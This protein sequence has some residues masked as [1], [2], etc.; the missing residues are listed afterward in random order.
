MDAAG[1]DVGAAAGESHRATGERDG[2]YETCGLCVLVHDDA[3]S[4]WTSVPWTAGV[5]ALPQR[6]ELSPHW[7]RDGAICEFLVPT[8]TIP[9]QEPTLADCYMIGRG[10]RAEGALTGVYVSTRR[11]QLDTS[12]SSAKTLSP[13]KSWRLLLRQNDPAMRLIL[14]LI[15]S[16]LR[17]IRRPQADLVLENLA[18]R[19]Q[20]AAYSRTMKQPRLKAAERL[21]W[22]ALS[23]A[24]AQWR[25]ALIVVKPATVIAWHR[26]GFQRYWRWRSRREL[27]A[28]P[29]ASWGWAAWGSSASVVRGQGFQT[30]SMFGRLATEDPPRAAADSEST[31]MFH[32]ARIFVRVGAACNTAAKTLDSLEPS[33]V[34]VPRSAWSP[35]SLGVAPGGRRTARAISIPHPR[36]MV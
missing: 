4:W 24:W 3:L 16:F 2:E 33:K 31:R 21:F 17:A 23:R 15:V 20:L 13:L 26:R 34:P 29:S 1:V 32:R 12:S 6:A 28:S 11:R 36:I 9:G 5:D 27:C 7:A 10:R 25:S 19:Q 30:P 8:G 35:P 14:A 22:A 18:F